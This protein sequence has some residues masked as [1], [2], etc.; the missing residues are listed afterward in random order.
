M[1]AGVIANKGVLMAP[2][3]V[4]KVSNIAGRTMWENKPVEDGRVVS[5]ETAA[6]MT[7]I[8]IDTVEN[9]IAT[10]AKV[11]GVKVAGK[12]GTS[13]TVRHGKLDAW[14]ICFAPADNPKVAI[15]VLGDQ[16]GQGKDVAA[17]IA[18]A[19]LREWVR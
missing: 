17:P 13:R 1:M 9:G 19:I 12:T 10:K 6:K 8:M 7:E 3:L 4:K 11:K 5:E 16:E 2:S 14:F 15:A 18:G